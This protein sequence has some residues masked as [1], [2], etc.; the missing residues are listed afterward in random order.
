MADAG[1]RDKV[2]CVCWVLLYEEPK[3]TLNKTNVCTHAHM[4]HMKG[5]STIIAK[6][7]LD[8]CQL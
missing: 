7:Y 6:A 2:F 1:L 4:L 3:A 5:I 8:T